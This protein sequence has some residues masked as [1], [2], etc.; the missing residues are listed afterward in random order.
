MAWD[1]ER[2]RALLL[3]AAAAEFSA[4]GFAGARVD[5]IAEAAGV[6]KERIYSYFGSKEALG[7]AVLEHCLTAVVDA[8][9][10]RGEGIAAIT[11][12]VDRL[13]DYH[14]AHPL[15]ARLMVW[16]GLERGIPIAEESR[17]AFSARKVDLLREAVPEPDGS[18]SSLVVMAVLDREW[19]ARQK[20]RPAPPRAGSPRAR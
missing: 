15:F 13:F 11:D 17:A 8:V 10:I 1:T 3:E 14:R 20:L 6:N 7:A 18:W 12:Y 19:A 4:H 5:R 2:T 9:P 16:E